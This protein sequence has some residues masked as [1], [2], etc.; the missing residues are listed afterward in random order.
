MNDQSEPLKQPSP[1]AWLD[2]KPVE[3]VSEE[4]R[5][6]RAAYQSIVDSLPLNLLIKDSQGRRVFANKSYLEL[7]G[8]SLDEV[9]GK[10][11]FDLFPQ[12][13]AEQFSDDDAAILKSG[14]A[15]HDVEK[16]QLPDGQQRWIERTK[17]A[18][19]DADGKIVG[20]Q[21]LFWDVTDREKA[22][23]DSRE[24]RDAANAANQ[25]KSDFL[26]NMS[27]EI[28]TPM[29]GIIGMT[30][31]VLDTELTPT[32]RSYLQMSQES[33]ESLLAIIND[34]LDFSKIEA[35]HFELDPAPFDPRDSLG[36]A[37][38]S[39]T[40]R[41]QSKGLEL[42]FSV[43]PEVPQMLEGDQGRLRQV[44]VNL[45]GNAIKFTDRGEVVLDVSCQSKSQ[46]TCTLR[47]S[48]RDT[49]IGIPADKQAR[50]FE[51]FQQADRSTTRSHGGTGLGLAISSQLVELMG[52]R[53]EVDS[54][55]GRG[56]TFHFTVD[57]PIVKSTDHEQTPNAPALDVA[58]NQLP[59]DAPTQKAESP[60][61]SVRVLLAEDNK[62]NQ[63]LA[64]KLLEKLGCHVT[65]VENG[66]QA[67]ATLS[68]NEFDVILMDVEMP[69]MDGISATK[70]IRR[71]EQDSQQ[72]I[73]IVALTAHAIVGDR[74]RCLASGMDDYLSKPV[75]INEIKTMLTKIL[76]QE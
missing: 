22:L 16:H 69:E 49:G 50:I 18:L 4:L 3:G 35:G 2:Q 33:G 60:L 42:E 28:R 59:S 30:D 27:H 67:V 61:E 19:R 11:D 17:S 13:L 39:L 55:T 6:A 37:V 74:E 73:P 23:I 56:S 20:V 44:I 54:A 32:Q 41:A 9:L 65:V 71:R 15:M 72:R 36:D 1:I 51:D 31:L 34:I 58:S 46:S 63:T 26:A 21:V 66:S 29:N 53:I 7:R 64:T 68:E 24:A 45:I 43:A 52:G 38:R 14:E 48:V 62:V 8:S 70:E 75:R 5:Q 12:A 40:T 47:F 57:F 10:T 76:L 25:A